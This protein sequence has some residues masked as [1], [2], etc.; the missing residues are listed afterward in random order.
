MVARSF[1]L[2]AISS[3]TSTKCSPVTYCRL[4]SPGPL[5][6]NV[7]IAPRE[8]INQKRPH[9]SLAASLGP[10]APRARIPKAAVGLSPMHTWNAHATPGALTRRAQARCLAVASAWGVCTRRRRTT[11][12]RRRAHRLSVLQVGR[13]TAGGCCC[14]SSPAEKTQLPGK[15][16]EGRAPCA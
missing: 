6:K 4:F 13:T 15:L 7:N 1:Y 5:R 11:A 2:Q 12:P 14:P 3:C 9:L 16:A 8:N 10:Q